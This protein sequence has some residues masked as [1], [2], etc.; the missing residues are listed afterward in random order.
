M[1]T[2]YITAIDTRLN[3]EDLEDTAMRTRLTC[4][5]LLAAIWVLALPAHADI[6]YKN[7]PVN[8]ICDIELCTVDAWTI[9]YGYSVTDSFTISSSSTIQGFNLAFWLLPG[10][11]LTSV[12]WSVGTC[13]FCNDIGEG[14]ASGASLSTSLMSTNQYGFD[15]WAVGITGLNIAVNAEPPDFYWLTLQNAVVGT[16]NPVYWDE[17]GGPSEAENQCIQN[18]IGCIPSESLNVVGTA[19]TGS[20]PEPGSILLFASGVIGIGGSFRRKLR[21]PE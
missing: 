14:T 19:G 21:K 16:G 7:G 9:N 20:V 5:L 6:L 3:I 4:L 8:G 18:Y 12:D 10:D 2:D 13:T 17:N 1:A 11:I 15:I